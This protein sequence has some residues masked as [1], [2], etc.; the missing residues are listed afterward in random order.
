MTAS[1]NTNNKCKKLNQLFETKPALMDNW[2]RLKKQLRQP[3]K[4]THQLNSRIEIEIRTDNPTK[5]N[6]RFRLN[7][8]KLVSIEP[9]GTLD[10]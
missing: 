6:K 1:N 7:R 5:M 9:E 3:N 8:N 10:N 4:K 2:F